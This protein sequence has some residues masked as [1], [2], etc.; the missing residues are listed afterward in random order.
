MSLEEVAARAALVPS[1]YRDAGVVEMELHGEG[2]E[3]FELEAP[4]EI[5]PAPADLQANLFD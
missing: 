2:V 4:E 3:G 5:E 1:E